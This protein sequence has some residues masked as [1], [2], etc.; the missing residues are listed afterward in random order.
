MRYPAEHKERVHSRIVDVAA[1]EFRRKGLGGVGIAD[2][3]AEAGLTHGTFYTHFKD[4]DALVGEAALRAAAESFGR[5]MDAA[6]TAKKG[7]EVEAMVRFYLDPEH[8]DDLACGCVL[9]ALAADLARQSEPI[10]NDFTGTLKANLARLACYMPGANERDR[11]LQA[12]TF[13]ASLVGGV[14]LARAV[15]DEAASKLML[16]GMRAQ[17][18]N[19]YGTSKGR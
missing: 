14:L 13:M 7:R 9:P 16:D 10:R 18:L 17:L 8:R 11:V 3:M 6:R 12:M 5:L 19:Q 2:L 4:R 1:Q 15:N